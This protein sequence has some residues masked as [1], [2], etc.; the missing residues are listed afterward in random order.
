MQKMTVFITLLF[1]F[2]LLISC[3]KEVPVKL[4]SS[5]KLVVIEGI[6]ET[7]QQPFVYLSNSIGFF[8]KI[9]LSNIS[10]I[11]GATV[12]V[13]DISSGQSITL[14]EYSIDTTIGS[15]TFSFTVY[16]PDI[17]DPVAM[18]FKGEVEHIYKLQVNSGGRTFESYAKIPASVGLDSV[19]TEP[20]PGREDSF[21]IV[22]ARYIDPDSFGNAVRLETLV[23]KRIKNDRPERYLTSFNSVYND[24]VINGTTLPV[25]IDIGYDKTVDY[26]QDEFQT[27]G[28][29]RRGDTLTIKWSAIDSKVFKFWETLSYSAGTIGNPFAAPSKIQSNIPGALGIWGAYNPSFYTLLDT[30]K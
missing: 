25:S 22:K 27:L 10:Y 23:N 21:S 9:D 20:V 19:W 6:I 2:M 13:A 30:L 29:L 17:S 24:D 16:G 4:S 11:K 7:N 18:N 1:S 14:K 28:F 15:N 12:V 3:E 8:D 26:T 5:E